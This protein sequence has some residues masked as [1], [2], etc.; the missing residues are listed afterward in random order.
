MFTSNPSGASQIP[1]CSIVQ[2]RALQLKVS[3][4]S[5][6]KFGLKGG[7]RTRRISLGCD[8]H[9]GIYIRREGAVCHGKVA[10][11]RPASFA[12]GRQQVGEVGRAGTASERF[13]APNR[14]R[15]PRRQ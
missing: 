9:V 7:I 14:N 4:K 11:G 8:C 5:R 1:K 3:P 2:A 10:H 12:A 13:A 6:P 15:V